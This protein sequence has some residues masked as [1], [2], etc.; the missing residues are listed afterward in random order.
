MPINPAIWEARVGGSQFEASPGNL[1][2][3]CHKRE[4]LKG[5]GHSSVVDQ[6]WVQSLVLPPD[7]APQNKQTKI[8]L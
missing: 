7:P 6:H 5:W 1:G 3:P 8:S 4:H 2:R